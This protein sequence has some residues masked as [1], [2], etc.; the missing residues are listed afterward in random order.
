MRQSKWAPSISPHD[1]DQGVYLVLDDFG[2]TAR[3][4]MGPDLFRAAS[5][6]RTG[7]GRDE[8]G[9]GMPMGDGRRPQNWPQPRGLRPEQHRRPAWQKTTCLMARYSAE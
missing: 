1:T 4:E 3:L 2:N 5:A 8:P 6:R 7:V 9:E